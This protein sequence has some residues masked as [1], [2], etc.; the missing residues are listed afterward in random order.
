M[1]LADKKSIFRAVKLKNWGFSRKMEEKNA[2]KIARILTETAKKVSFGSETSFVAAYLAFMLAENKACSHYFLPYGDFASS[3]VLPQAVTAAI[4]AYDIKSIWRDFAALFVSY[5]KEDFEAAVHYIGDTYRQSPADG[6]TPD[7][8]SDLALAFLDVKSGN[9]LFDIGSGCGSFLARASKIQ[10]VALCGSELNLHA[11]LISLLRLSLSGVTNFDQIREGDAFE[12]S[13]QFAFDGKIPSYKNTP[14]VF[15][16]YPFASRAKYLGNAAQK[17]AAEL[18]NQLGLNRDIYSADWLFNG[19]ACSM[20]GEGGTAVALMGCGSAWKENDLEIRRAFVQA[21]VIDAVIELP[22]K[23]VPG[24]SAELCLIVF[25][26]NKRGVKLIDARDVGI[27]GR[28]DVTFT[29]SQIAE[30]KRR[31]DDAKPVSEKDLAEAKC[32]LIASRFDSMRDGDSRGAVIA[33]PRK[34]QQKKLGEFCQIKRGSMISS[35]ELDIAICK[36]N[37]GIRYLTSGNIVL[38]EIEEGLPFINPDLLERRINLNL[39]CA[40]AGNIVMTKNGFPCRMALV[41][42]SPDRILVNN[43]LFIL[44]I[45]GTVADSE[46]VKLF[47]ESSRGMDLIKKSMVGG[48]VQSIDQKAFLNIA[49]PLPSLEKQKAFVKKYSVCAANIKKARKQLDSALADASKIL[50][51]EMG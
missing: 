46:Y 13:G 50:D 27:A 10:G 20:L 31:Y 38:G 33:R 32:C 42:E 8:I 2:K 41:S 3:R 9:R 23:I 37:S 5:E 47:L 22:A 28:R 4:S 7:S 26:I 34:V 51:K 39:Y 44:N 43:N 1:S 49:M 36:S 35:K 29:K 12:C 19:L 6:G 21:G 40:K 11:Y 16:N 45:D 30:I 18:K 15:A 24:T 25:G 48:N 14:K 17:F